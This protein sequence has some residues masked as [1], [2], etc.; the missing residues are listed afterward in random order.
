[1]DRVQVLDMINANRQYI[2]LRSNIAVQNLAMLHKSFDH[3]Q[4]EECVLALALNDS[5]AALLF[6]SDYARCIASSEAVIA[7]YPDSVYKRLLAAHEV[8][9][10]RCYVFMLRFDD[11]RPHLE[12]AEQIAFHEI[13]DSDDETIGL[14][15]DILHNI[16]MLN[17]FSEQGDVPT[18][19]YLRQALA[20][21]PDGRLQ[22][23]RGLCLMGVANVLSER[24]DHREAITYHEQAMALFEEVENYN[25]LATVLCNMGACYV[26]LGVYDKAQICLDRSLDMRTRLGTYWEISNAYYNLGM[27]Y[28]ARGEHSRGYDTMIIARD[29]A[30]VSQH[31]GLQTLILEELKAMASHM[32][33]TAAAAQHHASYLEINAD[34]AA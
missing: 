21:M 30:M 7:R 12:R 5:E 25:N 32:G 2:K 3:V 1:M 33:D 19:D 15:V 20:L 31:R 10:G 17:H 28:K 18:L 14:R 16:A 6:N 4:D 9:I 22:N 29:Y 34:I 24:G 8:L 23:R 26:R 13:D 27:L 11:S